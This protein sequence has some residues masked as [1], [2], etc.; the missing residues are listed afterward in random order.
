MTKKRTPPPGR[1]GRTKQKGGERKSQAKPNTAPSTSDQPNLRARVA[2]WPG[3]EPFTAANLEKLLDEVLKGQ[4]VPSDLVTLAYDLNDIHGAFRLRKTMGPESRNKQATAKRVREAIAV[5]Q[6]FFAEREQAFRSMEAISPK[7]MKAEIRLYQR[8]CLFLMAMQK[9]DFQLNM[10]IDEIAL[11]PEAESWHQIAGMI[12]D[13][14]MIAMHPQ[15]LGLS[16]KGPVARFVAV[17]MPAM[18]GES[19]S[20]DSVAQHLKRRRFQQ[21]QS[22]R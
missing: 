21:G 5:L 16:N 22:K 15:K 7:T 8:F 4:A 2:F 13:A 17:V 12:A 9:H 10:D 14:F 1:T 20:I 3:Q 18:T 6:N 11:M 19:P